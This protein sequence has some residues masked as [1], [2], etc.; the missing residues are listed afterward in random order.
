MTEKRYCYCCRN[1]HAADEMVLFDTKAGKRWRCL[2][3]IEAARLAPEIRDFFGRQ[4]S[5]E[6]KAEA[7]R[8]ARNSLELRHSSLAFA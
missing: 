6:N 7:S 2:R 5:A 3:S 1:H 8:M 4:Q